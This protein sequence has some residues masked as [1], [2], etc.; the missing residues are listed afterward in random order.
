M[1]I[2]DRALDTIHEA[3]AIA[4]SLCLDMHSTRTSHLC[5]SYVPCSLQVHHGWPCEPTH[6]IVRDTVSH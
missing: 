3:L 2:R 5:S 1:T 4:G 6:N